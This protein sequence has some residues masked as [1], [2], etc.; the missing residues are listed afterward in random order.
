MRPFVTWKDAIEISTCGP[1]AGAVD[2]GGG[3]TGG[4]DGGDDAAAIG[5]STMPP[6][7]RVTCTLGA[8]MR[9][10]PRRARSGDG[11]ALAFFGLG[12]VMSSKATSIDFAPTE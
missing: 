2:G 12:A 1:A 4:E 10:S 8:A 7:V 3:G 11:G 6:A 9:M 5:G